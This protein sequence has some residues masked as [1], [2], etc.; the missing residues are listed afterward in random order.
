[1]TPEHVA[2][3][4]YTR[5]ELGARLLRIAHEIEQGRPEDRPSRELVIDLLDFCDD[6]F[7]QTWAS[8]LPAADLDELRR[9]EARLL[10]SRAVRE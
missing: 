9:L 3:T 2:P 8:D 4:Q 7:A 5:Q 10:A 1:M 6:L